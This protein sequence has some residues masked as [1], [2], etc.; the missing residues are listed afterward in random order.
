MF[1][2][3]WIPNQK[4]FS[5]WGVFICTNQP[6]PRK[7]PGP[8]FPGPV[9]P[10]EAYFSS[11]PLKTLRDRVNNYS[12]E[13]IEELVPSPHIT[14]DR[15][16]QRTIATVDGLTQESFVHSGQSDYEDVGHEEQM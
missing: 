4:R 1:L 5:F 3:I 9:P 10:P 12:R 14:N 8:R 16:G 11:A 15:N 13:K 6:Y 2:K 7:V